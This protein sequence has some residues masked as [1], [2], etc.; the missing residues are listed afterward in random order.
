MRSIGVLTAIAFT[1][2]PVAVS[3]ETWTAYVSGLNCGRGG[4][5]YIFTLANNTFTASNRHGQLFS[6][7]VPAD[8]VIDKTYKPLS[9]NLGTRTFEIT[10][11]V[12]S[13]ELEILDTDIHCRYKVT[14]TS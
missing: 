5:T 11:N 13:R 1:V 2:V 14:P 9:S 10:G 6:I 8:G 7:T 4:I 12:K 3:A